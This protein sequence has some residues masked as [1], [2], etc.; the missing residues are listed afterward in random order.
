MTQWYYAESGKQHGPIPEDV[1]CTLLDNGKITPETPVWRVGLP[2]WKKM[3]ELP[4]EVS[5]L[6]PPL[7]DEST[8][9]P[10]PP[11]EPV[12][13]G[14]GL[15]LAALILDLL[16][17]GLVGFVFFIAGVVYH[18]EVQEPS[19]LLCWIYLG[20]GTAL[21]WIYFVGLE[22]SRRQATWGMQAMEIRVISLE[23]GRLSFRAAASRF[24]LAFFL[25]IATFG[26]SFLI[27]FFTRR[28]QAMHDKVVGTL[29]VKE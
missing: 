26:I 3:G 5:P 11:P 9:P 29:V 13:A 24:M 2:G 10:P 17:L 27:I 22:C 14:F 4:P 18:G 6:P 12:M 1:L 7:V 15:R 19:E 8:L 23:G 20:A 25:F 16:V 21:V 28:K